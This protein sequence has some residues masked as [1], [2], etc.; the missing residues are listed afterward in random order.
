MEVVIFM[1]ARKLV[2][3][4]AGALDLLLGSAALAGLI[5]VRYYYIPRRPK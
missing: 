1:I 2:T 5:I 3:Q 4:G